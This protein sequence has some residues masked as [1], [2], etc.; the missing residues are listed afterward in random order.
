MKH[1]SIVAPAQTRVLVVPGPGCRAFDALYTQVASVADVRL[2]DLSPLESKFNPKTFPH[3][4]ILFSYSR[5]KDDEVFLHDFEPFRKTF[6]VISVSES[7]EY[8]RNPTAIVHNHLVFGGG[9]SSDPNVI[10]VDSIQTAMCAVAQNYLVALDAYASL[11]ENITL[12]S[13]VSLT[14]NKGLA[15][16]I[17]NA[18]KRGLGLYKMLFSPPQPEKVM[19]QRQT[20]RQVKL[21]GNFLLLAGRCHDALQYFTDAAINLRKAEDHL[22]LASALDGLAVALLLLAYLGLPDRPQNPMLAQVL[23]ARRRD[24]SPRSSLSSRTSV[25]L[26]VPFVEHIRLLNHRALYY[27]QLST[28]DIENCVPDVVYVELLIRSIRFMLAVHKPGT[29]DAIAQ[30]IKTDVRFARREI[31]AEI[32]KIFLL[33]L[34]DLEFA[35]QCRVYCAMALIYGDLGLP[36]KRL[37]ILRILLVAL[38]PKVGKPETEIAKTS[39]YAIFDNLLQTHLVNAPCERTAT[40]ANAHYSDWTALQLLLLKVCYRILESLKDHDMLAKLCILLLSR[41][42]HCLTLEDQAKLKEKLD[43]LTVTAEIPYPDPY[44]VRAARIV[45]SAAQ[46][47]AP[48]SKPKAAEGPFIFDPYAKPKPASKE[49]VVCAHDVLHMRVTLQNPFLFD[50]TVAHIAIVSE[51]VETLKHLTRRAQP[52]KTPQLTIPASLTLDVIVLFKVLEAGPLCIRHLE[53]GINNFH[54][55]KFA[56]VNHEKVSALQRCKHS[57]KSTE[58]C[59][60]NV[61]SFDISERAETTT[62]ALKVVPAQPQLSLTQNLIANGWLMLFEGERQRFWIELRNTSE[63]AINYLAFSF[64]DSASELIAQ[65]LQ[66]GLPPD[67]TYELERQYFTKTFVVANKEEIAARH[68]VFEPGENVR[69]EYEICG[70]RGMRELKLMLEYAHREGDAPQ[71]AKMVSVPIKVS[72]RPALDIIGCDIMPVFSLL[73]QGLALSEIAQKNMERLLRFTATA[74]IDRFC[75]LVLDVRNLWREKLEVCLRNSDIGFEVCE[76]LEATKTLRFLLP[77]RLISADRLLGDPIPSLRNKQFVKKDVDPQVLRTFWVKNRLLEHLAGEWRTVDKQTARR[78]TLD[79]RHV[80]LLPAM[81]NMLVYENI[82]V[83]HAILTSD[84]R[85]VARSKHEYA[86]QREALYILRTTI[87]NGTGAS[88]SGVLRHIPYV[89]TEN[90]QILNTDLRILYN[91]VLQRHLG[92]DAIAAGATYEVDLGFM[93]LEKGRYEWGCFF[94]AAGQKVAAREPLHIVV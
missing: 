81:A 10:F 53:V 65:K 19:L 84:R 27:Y 70:R 50:L 26:Q 47:L 37:F 12:R 8:A 14:N 86:L 42:T 39:I 63:K 32:D 52:A 64:W 56:I 83:Q 51:K 1:F 71:F 73:L 34:V 85:E 66:G 90:R 93:V 29:G 9:H 30:L 72:V 89:A 49:H 31:I 67:E 87:A 6:I 45:N 16:T 20:G 17:N 4:R 76:V 74:E 33:Q 40:L 91:G 80:R 54:P 60:G 38:L 82:Q 3:G 61:S 69:I 35:A 59:L 43:W 79:M 24:D 75:L 77:V 22:W 68:Q 7:P 62:L 18:Q 5:D 23:Q 21:M 41:Y 13:P 46:G 28:S 11:Y 57:E 88:V 55:Q 92:P 15:R 94:D 58:L 25:E 48:L 2:L 36:R 44:L 78:G